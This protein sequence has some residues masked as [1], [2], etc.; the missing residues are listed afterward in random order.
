MIALKN[1]EEWE[2]LM[3]DIQELRVQYVTDSSGETTAVI[4]PIDQFRE[5]LQVLEGF[6]PG[7]QG[8]DESR[9]PSTGFT[10]ETTSAGST[11][12]SSRSVL[13]AF[14]LKAWEQIP[15][16]PEGEVE[17]DIEETVAAVRGAP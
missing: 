4:L 2:E 12:T 9:A 3:P 8:L 15:E 7:S 6:A 5:L 16:M 13:N 11:P 1:V 14:L 10:E 17:R